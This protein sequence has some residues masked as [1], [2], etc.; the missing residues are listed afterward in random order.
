MQPGEE[1]QRERDSI[2]G[3][4]DELKTAGCNS[5]ADPRRRHPPLLDE[6]GLKPSG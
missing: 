6:I 3:I 2:A 1:I 4:R 5:T